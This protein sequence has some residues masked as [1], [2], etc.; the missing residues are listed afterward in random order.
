MQHRAI[1]CAIEASTW[2]NLA[3]LKNS[4]S[5]NPDRLALSAS[6]DVERRID[7]SRTFFQAYGRL[8][9]RLRKRKRTRHEIP[10][11]SILKLNQVFIRC[12]SQSAMVKCAQ[13]ESAFGSAR[14]HESFSCAALAVHACLATGS[15][16]NCLGESRLHRINGIDRIQNHTRA[17][18]ER[19]I[20]WCITFAAMVSL[21]SCRCRSIGHESVYVICL[22]D[23]C[24]GIG[25]RIPTADLRGGI[26]RTG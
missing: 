18:T 21:Y 9:H 25:Q 8:H 12:R 3:Q 24:I 1:R 11:S 23:A 20:Q 17:T 10:S 5:S 7:T 6:D 26:A 13:S 2:P 4:E 22:I 16:A 14:R 15:C 19:C